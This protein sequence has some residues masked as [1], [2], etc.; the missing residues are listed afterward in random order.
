MSYMLTNPDGYGHGYT[1]ITTIGE[2]VNDT[3]IDFGILK[4]NAGEEIDLSCDLEAAY[5]LMNGE[6]CFKWE[7][8]EAAVKRESLFDEDPY[9]L[10]LAANK[11]VSAKAISDCEIAVQKVHNDKDFETV[12]FDKE[13]MLESEHRGKGQ[14]SDTSYRIVRTIFDTRNRPDAM[15]VLGEVVNFSGRWSSYP[16]H[17]H[18][19]P[20][21]YHYRFTEPQGYGHGEM[22][23]DVYKVKQ[24]HTLKI[25]D[26][27][28]HAQCSAP[29]YGMYYV[30]VIRHL[31][32]DPY[33]VP[34]FTEE[35]AWT[36]EPGA[37]IWG[38]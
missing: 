9:A 7:D 20:E 30:W 36:K 12:L 33:I 5:L 28:D 17:H 24:Y 32:D 10:H 14:L 11:P 18:P 34:E 3:G 26:E 8:I 22:G 25:L 13:N 35:H 1:P 4:M 15:L 31:P 2:E 23:D 29:G 27:K 16:P 6:I 21:I 19:Q 37:E 38:I